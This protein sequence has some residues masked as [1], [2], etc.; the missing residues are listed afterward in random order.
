M[1]PR[2]RTI[3]EAYSEIKAADPSTAIT[4]HA[5]RRLLLDGKI[6]YITA[7]KKYLVNLDTLQ[8]YLANPATERASVMH[9]G[10][11]KIPERL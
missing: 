4:P 11:R 5:I 6:P 3:K 1:T 10:I 8:S 2:M 7:G 9:S